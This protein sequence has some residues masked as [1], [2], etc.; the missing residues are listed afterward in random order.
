[1]ARAIKNLIFK[2]LLI[3]LWNGLWTTERYQWKSHTTVEYPTEKLHIP[4]RFRG[5]LIVDMSLCI[6]CK[7]CELA[8]PTKVITVVKNPDK[9]VKE[10]QEFVIDYGRCSFCGLCVDPCPTN[11][12]RHHEEY[13]LASYVYDDLYHHKDLVGR[14]WTEI[15]Q[16]Q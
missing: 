10:P 16:Y 11:A 6:A 15:K 7:I 14:K 3:D 12:I 9:N 1:M 13:E 2:I 5:R 4:E 8:C